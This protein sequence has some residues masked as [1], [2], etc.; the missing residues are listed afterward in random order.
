MMGGLPS[1]DDAPEPGMGICGVMMPDPGAEPEPGIGI[2]CGIAPGGAPG[3]AAA[4][5]CCSSLS[6]I[7]WPF[8]WKTARVS[9][10]LCPRV[11]ETSVKPR[12]GLSVE[13]RKCSWLWR[14]IR[15]A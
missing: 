15:L 13:T 11:I 12:A 6:V 14:S 5:A 1:G 3:V 4:T 8:F 7:V 10:P 2:C 9:E